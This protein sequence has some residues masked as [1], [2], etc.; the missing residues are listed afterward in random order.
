MSPLATVLYA[1][2]YTI[3]Y[4]G[5]LFSQSTFL[6]YYPDVSLTIRICFLLLLFSGFFVPYY[7][8]IL[9][10]KLTPTRYFYIAGLLCFLYACGSRYY[11]TGELNDRNFHSFLQIMPTE[12]TAA[13]PKPPDV[14]RII[15]LGGS[16]TEGFQSRGYPAS[17][18][19]MLSDKYPARKIEVLNAGKYF[20]STEHSI[21]QYLFYLKALEPD[22]L[23]LFHAVND[24]IASFTMPPFSSKPFRRDYGHFYGPLA[25]IR[26]PRTFEQFLREFFFADLLIPHLKPILFGDFKSQ[27]SFR[28]NLETIIKIAQCDGVHLILS[29][30]AH[31]YSDKNDSDPNFLKFQRYFL[32]DEH[33]YADEKSWYQGM[34]LFNSITRETAEKNLVSFVDQAAVFNGRRE[35]FRES[36]HLTAEGTELLAKLFFEK[37]VELKLVIP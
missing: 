12:Q 9:R 37:I 25:N 36:V 34:E 16:T 32:V 30:Q 21:I 17:L 24:L 5:L 8:K 23:I 31:C 1:I 15:C 14:F 7:L 11:Y 29:N 28:Q 4:L 20:Y 27:H 10:I 18:Q 33:H 19:R 26:Y 22:V 13:I 35:L 6:K 3:I 2:I